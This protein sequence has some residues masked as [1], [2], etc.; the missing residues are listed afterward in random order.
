MQAASNVVIRGDQPSSGYSS[1]TSLLGFSSLEEP[2]LSQ[3]YF[4]HAFTLE[5]L[6][7]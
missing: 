5:E 1:L 2:G 4:I 6:P 7:Q 3:P